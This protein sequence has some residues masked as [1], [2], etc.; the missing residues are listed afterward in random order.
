MLLFRALGGLG[1][2][3]RHGRKK[4]KFSEIFFKILIVNISASEPSIEKILRLPLNF[5]QISPKL[6]KLGDCNFYQ[7]T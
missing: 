5:F 3:N 2:E 7:S 1:D 4:K 6:Q